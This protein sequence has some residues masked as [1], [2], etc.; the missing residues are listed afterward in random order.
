MDKLNE[1]LRAVAKILGPFLIA[2]AIITPFKDKIA[3]WI[4]VHIHNIIPGNYHIIWACTGIDEVILL[5]SAIFATPAPPKK[6]IIGFAL[7]TAIFEAY[8]VLRIW[9]TSNHPNPLLHDVLFRW[10][11]FTLVLL[12]FWAYVKVIKYGS[13]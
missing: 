11:G 10:G 4:D 8:N 6:K 7:A 3:A 2:E 9:I 1:F 5:S 13:D 12:L